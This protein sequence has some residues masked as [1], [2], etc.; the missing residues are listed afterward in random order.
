VA[1]NHKRPAASSSSRN[2]RERARIGGREQASQQQPWRRS[3]SSSDPSCQ[4]P[5]QPCMQPCM[6]PPL[7]DTP[8]VV[9]AKVLQLVPASP[10]CSRAQ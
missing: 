9:V 7:A 4:P 10:V 2:V 3:S 5:Q 6:Q 8:V 1:F